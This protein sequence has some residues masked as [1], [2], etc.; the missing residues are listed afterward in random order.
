MTREETGN[1]A[2]GKGSDERS[3]S[4]DRSAAGEGT[5]PAEWVEAAARYRTILIGVPLILAAGVV[6]AAIIY[7]YRESLDIEAWEAYEKARADENAQPT[8]R[9]ARVEG[10]L[11][12]F[13]SRDVM[14]FALMHL[15]K[16]YYDAAME[17]PKGSQ[18]R[19]A[20]LD[21]ALSFY[22]TMN[23]QFPAHTLSPLSLEGEGLV[24]EEKGDLDGAV[25]AFS[26]AHS[27]CGDSHWIAPK[28]FYD[29]GRCH[30]FRYREKGR[31]EDLAEARR[32]LNRA[33]EF[34]IPRINPYHSRLSSPFGWRRDVDLLLSLI[35]QPGPG[36]PD[37]KA[38]PE[39]KKQADA[40]QADVKPSGK[41]EGKNT[42]NL[43]TGNSVPDSKKE[44]GRDAARPVAGE[45]SQQKKDAARTE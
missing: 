44:A 25:A 3:R 39:R 2:A 27:S 36:L 33:K 20:F 5:L 45:G 28:L 41:T 29:I 34:T 7:R 8:E 30:Y 21:K 19:A 31:E 9:L 43:P 1:V 14:P 11:E 4:S 18:E 38:P 32:W 12:K 22:E 15:A 37:G 13:K 6:A 16:G 17:K 40:K 35:S 23:R 26:K 10:L 24:K 42:E